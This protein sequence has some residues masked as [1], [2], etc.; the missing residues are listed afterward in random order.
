MFREEAK[1]GLLSWTGESDIVLKTRF[2][3]SLAPKAVL[4]AVAAGAVLLVGGVANA[5]TPEG[6]QDTGTGSPIGGLLPGAAGGHD[7]GHLVGPILQP[8]LGGL[9]GGTGGLDPLRLVGPLL[10]PVLG[11]PAGGTGGL[12]LGQLTGPLLGGLGS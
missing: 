10:Q 3:N 8:I 2:L 5:D 4:V 11:G 1:E 12:D 7:L 9:S 6:P